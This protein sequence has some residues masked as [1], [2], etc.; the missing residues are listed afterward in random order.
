MQ[1]SKLRGAL[2]FTSSPAGFMPCP[3]SVMYGAT[4]AF[5]TTFG[6]SLAPEVAVDGID[7]LV[8]HPSPVTS[9]FYNKAHKLDAIEMFRKTGTSP[10]TIASAMLR[11]VGRTTVCDQG[12]YCLCVRLLLKVSLPACVVTASLRACRR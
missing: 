5:L 12:Y 10:A 7:V 4:K 8:V 9:N 3:F 1:D 2:V 6:M 11:S